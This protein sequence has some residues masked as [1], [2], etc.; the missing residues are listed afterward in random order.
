ML[1]TDFKAFADFARE[2]VPIALDDSALLDA[3]SYSEIEEINDNDFLLAIADFQDV[4][5]ADLK[6]LIIADLTTLEPNQLRGLFSNLVGKA[7]VPGIVA[8]YDQETLNYAI[9]PIKGRYRPVSIDT[10]QELITRIETKHYDKI[11]KLVD[12]RASGKIKTSEFERLTAKELKALHMQTYMLGRGGVNAMTSK[13]KMIFQNILRTE[14]SYFK[15]FAAELKG[16]KLSL[17]R[18][19]D[20]ASMYSEKT[21]GFYETGRQQS[22]LENGFIV[23]RRVRRATESCQPCLDFAAQS[24]QSIGAL[25]NPT[26]DCTCR[27][28]CKCIKEYSKDAAKISTAR[29][30]QGSPTV[31]APVPSGN[32][33][34]GDRPYTETVRLGKKFFGKDLSDFKQTGQIF[35]AEL[36]KLQKQR[37]SLL[38]AVNNSE[39]ADAKTYLGLLDKLDAHDLR[40]L[41]SKANQTAAL[42][43]QH[44][45]LITKILA[46]SKIMAKDAQ[47]W[48]VKNINLGKI[49]FA[50]RTAWKKEMALF[51]QVA[52]GKIDTLKYVSVDKNYETPYALWDTKYINLGKGDTDTKLPERDRIRRILWHEMSHHVEFSRSNIEDLSIAWRKDVSTDLLQTVPGY[53]DDSEVVGYRSAKYRDQYTGRKYA[54]ETVGDRTGES[55]EILSTGAEELASPNMLYK[56]LQ[57]EEHLEHLY[58]SVGL[59]ISK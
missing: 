28:R 4:T 31:P 3:M 33:P 10:V 7:K 45:K 30:Q 17:A 40:E 38:D 58:L 52:N 56:A 32:P 19:R 5:P 13:D 26:F 43:E 42:T 59:L 54:K 11:S 37:I 44:D 20:R 51:Y 50:N 2:L 22:A 27:S 23:E 6:N 36:A 24:W 18:F 12:R 16:D 9:A 14:L 39:N 15:K 41:K 57:N 29:P 8:L 53:G 34:A 47:D 55:T 46:Q 49:P 21:R 1:C 35:D 48:V 25:P